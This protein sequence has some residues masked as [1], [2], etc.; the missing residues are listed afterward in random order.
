ME[1]QIVQ[2][3][4]QWTNGNQKHV[5]QQLKGNVGIYLAAAISERLDKNQSRQFLGRLFEQI[6]IQE[7]NDAS[8]KYKITVN[9]DPDTENP[10]TDGDGRWQIYT[11]NSKEFLKLLDPDTDS[12]YAVFNAETLA[13]LKTGL[14][15]VDNANG[16]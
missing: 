6:S 8:C 4:E 2:L 15:F 12:E 3:I 10:C 11:T 14:A 13:K 16:N 5:I 1:E 9:H 7:I